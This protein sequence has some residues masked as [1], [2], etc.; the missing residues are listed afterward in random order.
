[1]PPLTG[2][3]P[4]DESTEEVMRDLFAWLEALP[5][6]E[7]KEVI[8]RVLERFCAQC[9][10]RKPCECDHLHAEGNGDKQ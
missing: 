7:R 2:V 8:N 4:V 9:G 3:R 1:M 10:S 6:E 5:P